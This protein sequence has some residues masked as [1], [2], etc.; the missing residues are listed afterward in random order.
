VISEEKQN[1]ILY[2]VIIFLGYRL[3]L[4]IKMRKHVRDQLDGFRVRGKSKNRQKFRRLIKLC[5][6]I[7]KFLKN[8]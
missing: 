3:I 8:V 2:P 5:K 7:H 4:G 1:R 6:N